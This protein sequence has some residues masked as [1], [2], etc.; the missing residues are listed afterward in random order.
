MSQ[1]TFKADLSSA[2]VLWFNEEFIPECRKKYGDNFEIAVV[3]IGNG[4]KPS[5]QKPYEGANPLILSN[6][7]VPRR[8]ELVKN[9]WGKLQFVLRTGRPSSD[10]RLRPD[11]IEPGDFPFEGAGIYEDRSGGASGD[12]EEVD[13]WTF[14]RCVDK[15]NQLRAEM[16]MPAVTACK[17][18]DRDAPD[19]N[20]KFLRYLEIS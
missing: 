12:K 2:M 20:V 13:W 17:N 5:W 7:D 18:R 19:D 1:A 10:A 9:V 15:Y 14:R 8:D 16:V 6:V 4:A 3:I 11:L